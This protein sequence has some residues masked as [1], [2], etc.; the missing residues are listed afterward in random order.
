MGSDIPREVRVDP[1]TGKEPKT[2]EEFAA[3]NERIADYLVERAAQEAAKK[4]E[5][6]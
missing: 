3:Q 5:A 2:A 1:K 4:F 6:G